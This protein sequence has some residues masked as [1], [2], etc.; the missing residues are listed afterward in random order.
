M[1]EFI[2]IWIAYS[3]FGG[4]VVKVCETAPIDSYPEPP[5]PYIQKQDP[6]GYIGPPEVIAKK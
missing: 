3:G 1:F 2:C 4:F 6:P 5:P